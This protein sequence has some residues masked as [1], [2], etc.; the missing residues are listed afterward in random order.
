MMSIILLF[1][2]ISLFNIEYS[3]HFINIKKIDFNNNYL[4]V[5]TDGLYLYNDNLLN[6]SKIFSFNSS[7]YKNSG[8]KIILTK[9]EEESNS[10]ILCLINKY[11]FFYNAKKNKIKYHFLNDVAIT[12]DIY[13]NI[14]PYKINGNF[15]SFILVLSNSA[16]LNFYYYDLNI[17]NMKIVFKKESAFYSLM[18]TSNRIN[19]QI[20]SYLSYI[21]CFSYYTNDNNKFLI[22]TIFSIDENN[23][24]I[25]NKETYNYT[26]DNIVNEIK[27][28]LSFN[29][30][31]FICLSSGDEKR[32]VCYINVYNQTSHFEK[33]DCTF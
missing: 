7:I 12:T 18:I 26:L 8:N 30:K 31:F 22:S 3:T 16:N 14:M 6:C 33:M 28:V 27:S 15:L 4:V 24:D 11:L 10:F 21:N 19:C 20:D 29:N 2:F 17:N 5:L 13:C 1:T 9:L 25:K 23:F 32:L